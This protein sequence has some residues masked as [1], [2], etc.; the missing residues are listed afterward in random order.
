MTDIYDKV[1]NQRLSV[2]EVVYGR[3]LRSINALPSTAISATSNLAQIKS[4][5]DSNLDGFELYLIRLQLQIDVTT[6]EVDQYESEKLRLEREQILATQYTATLETAKAS[7]H[8]RRQQLKEYNAIV[9]SM[10]SQHLD[11]T[12]EEVIARI[13]ELESDLVD[14]Q[15]EISNGKNI[16]SARKAQF[17][18]IL[19]ALHNMQ[20]QINQ[21][22][23][24]ESG[25]L[26]TVHGLDHDDLVGASQTQSAVTSSN[27]AQS[28]VMDLS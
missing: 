27:P 3:L 28:S 18:Q 16:W 23:E 6:Q 7:S 11:A 26:L 24:T 15:A 1:V 10:N 4:A 17:S 19:D 21:E 13:A 5:I 8:G 20:I 22:M 25:R 9:K 2:N 14:L 12:R